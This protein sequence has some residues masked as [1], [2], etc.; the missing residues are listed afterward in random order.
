[1]QIRQAS[2]GDGRR[3]TELHVLARYD[4]AYLPHVY[5]FA[6]I[7][8]WMRE[9]VL[10]RQQVWVAEL[11]RTVVGYASLHEAYL[12]DLYVHPSYQRDGI[13][14]ALFT[15]VKES[16]PDGFKFW[17]FEANQDAIRFYEKHGART[18]RAVTDGSQNVE[19]LPV[20]LM[21][22]GAPE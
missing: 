6:S 7:E 12:T 1:M 20:R 21:C 5:S 19:G 3:V 2:L 16:A 18:V 4:M 9:A 13:G 17:V 14:A 8:K 11:D 15:E 10:P 22:W